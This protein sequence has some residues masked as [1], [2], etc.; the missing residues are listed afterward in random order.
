MRLK[1]TIFTIFSIFLLVTIVPSR[2][3]YAAA[4]NWVDQDYPKGLEAALTQDAVN[5]PGYASHMNTNYMADIIR[6]ISGPVPGITITDDAIRRNPKYVRQLAQESAIAG[7]S[8]F[9]IAMY[10]NPPASTSL[11]IQDLGQT[12]G[13]IPPQAYAQGI[14]FSGLSPLLKIWRAFRNIAY[15]LLAV[16]MIVIGFMVMLRKRIDPKTVVTVQNALPRIILTLLLIT[17]SYAIVGIMIDLMYL[18]IALIVTMFKS[19]GLLGE[20]GAVAKLFGY[21]TV[22]EVFGRGGLFAVMNTIFP[23]SGIDVFILSKE[24]LGWNLVS[25]IVGGGAGALVGLIFSPIGAVVGGVAGSL[26]PPILVALLISLALLFTF[27]RLFIMFLSAYIQIIFSLI[28]APLHLLMDAFPGGLGFSSWMKNLIANLAVFPVAATMF[29]LSM[30]FG[31]VAAQ[32]PD[33]LWA[34]PYLSLSPSTSGIAA[35]FSLGVLFVIPSIANSIKEALKAKPAV[36]VGAGSI[37]AP[38]SAVWTT[39]LGQISQLYYLQQLTR[40]ATG[41]KGLLDVL[42]FK[43]KV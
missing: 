43:K 19:T 9:I 10:A 42:G 18:S 11:A 8:G 21:S 33:K 6:K 23:K 24:I 2:P 41:G 26:G 40:E 28:I 22:E 4:E 13:F 30:A 25:G 5:S 36:P 7:I 14:G 39:S 3:A 29:L 34:P 31:T 15:L 35:L 1:T 17:F 20:P 16:V 12:L 32:T 27:I 38:L 37:T